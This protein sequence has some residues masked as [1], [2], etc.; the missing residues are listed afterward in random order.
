MTKLGWFP[1]NTALQ[2]LLINTC[3]T[4]TLSIGFKAYSEIGSALIIRGIQ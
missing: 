4:A 3:Y 1:F 2:S